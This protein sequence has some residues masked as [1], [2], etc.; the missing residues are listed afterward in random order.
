MRLTE[1]EGI[2]LSA[3]DL[4]G[5]LACHHLTAS[6][7]SAARGEIEPPPWS[8]PIL[9]AIRERGLE[10]EAKYLEQLR[11]QD[12]ELH[13]VSG[14]GDRENG[15]ARTEQAMRAGAP[16]IVQAT[17]AS[18]GWLG[19]ADV[20]LRVDEPSDLGAWSYEVVDTK[21]ARETS[22][23][24]I[25][26]LCL[27]SELVREIQGTLP[28]QMH[29]VSPGRDFAPNSYRVLDYLA[30]HRWVKQQLEI[31]VDSQ[32]QGS[33][34]E[35]YPD[36]CSHCEVCRWRPICVRRRRA[37]DHLCL[38]AGI[39]KLQI[40]ELHSRGIEHLETLARLPL[41]LEWKPERGSAEGY[42]RV[43]EQARVQLQARDE[44]RPVFELLPR[45]EERGLAR[46]PEP[47][48]RDV[49]FDIEGDSFAGDGGRE[50][51]FGYAFEGTQG[52]LEYKSTWALE[53]SKERAMFEQFVA[54]MMQRWATDP[55]FHIYH[56][57]AYEPSTLK[58]L[59]GRYATCED[60]IDRML[61]AGV[62]VDLYSV[63]RQSILA[64]V[65]SYSI[66]KLEPL[67]GYTREEN[68][69]EVRAHLSAVERALELGEADSLPD[70]VLKAVETY[71]RD[72][73]IATFKLRDWLESLRAEAVATGE[74][75][76]RPSFEPG[77]PSE[78]LSDRQLAIQELTADLLREVPEDP[79]IWTEVHKALWRLAHML[80]W[81]W[82]EEKVAWWE[83][84]RLV[85][86]DPEEFLDER[87]GVSGLRFKDTVGGTSRCPIH[88]YSYPLQEVSFKEGDTLHEGEVKIGSVFSIDQAARRLDV[89]KTQK[90]AGQH[91]SAVFAHDV[92]STGV[93]ASA[94][95]RF[96]Q[97]VAVH[98]LDADGSFRAARDLL[99][100]AA[101]RF[102]GGATGLTRGPNEET[103][104]FAERLALE[105][106]QGT[107]PVQGPPGSGKTF[108][109]ARMIC[110]LVAAGK[111][112]G[113]T[114]NSHK[115]IRNLLEEVV[116]AARERKQP[117]T[118]VEKVSDLSEC[119]PEGIL[120]VSKNADVL[121][122]LEGGEAQVAAG[123]AW[124]WARDEYFES[125][126]ILFVDEAGQ[127]S[128]AN[129]LA[130][131]QAGKS[132]VLLGDPQQLEQPQQG[133]HPEGTDVSALEHILGES[134]TIADDR[135]LFLPE[136]WRLHPSLS[137]FTS[138]VFYD[139]RLRSR[140]EL[141]LQGIEGR[142]PFGA[143]GLWFV[144]VSHAGNQ[145]SSPEEAEVVA[146]LIARLTAPGSK[147]TTAKGIENPLGLDEV[148]I[149]APYN[150]QVSL[151]SEHL[152]PDARVGTVDK[153]QGQEAPVVIYSM[154]TSTP[155]EA[156]R[157]MEFLYSPNRL[158]VATSRARCACI[159]VGNPL[160]FEPDC[161]TPRQMELANAF[162]R[163][164]E[165]SR[166][167]P[168]ARQKSS[169]HKSGLEF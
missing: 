161:R 114:A 47:T 132:L 113:I 46:L 35:T 76:Q 108:S 81:H 28:R 78:K 59:M 85:E 1:S 140:P 16:A 138:E 12:V 63:A 39:S 110:T 75:I 92:V 55:G 3:T 56:Y 106:D 20:L 25:L 155:E 61:R 60:E 65:E 116:K 91:P 168:W 32:L 90:A 98:G 42:V 128:L 13:D 4:A 67:F 58:R 135:G 141:E 21:L 87:A 53:T 9:A 80:G 139:G 10:H 15:V 151:L 86:M 157:G 34:E 163:Y 52:R 95:F 6:N 166:V 162:C 27:Y 103:L 123:T 8:N 44:K 143:P 7:I 73:C 125:V 96:G 50:Y 102:A 33:A 119:E 49:F 147:W 153:F 36:P 109:G 94:L 99:L 105:L 115:V 159:L 72:D 38:V 45:E 5:H 154:T 77:D 144:P 117:L 88:Q 48:S 133:S 146:E 134:D 150:A 130:V 111:K 57:A 142:E 131:A 118:C 167:V 70:K 149:V 43:R 18:D 82:R 74:K 148:L 107:L 40:K 68:L 54:E 164:L 121:A 37:D 23:G 66:K 41:P 124:L 89:K 127:M 14:V 83:Y 71:N 93:L 22:G 145:S 2:R 129:A 120:E 64:G 17:L 126:D 79:E 104:G 29:V 30:Y 101:P 19:I 136:T 69:E 122:A 169:S 137:E 11:G 62:F 160:L 31:F 158:N 156:P 165:I 100:S 51:L 112:V 152:G 97:W 26:Q 24:T 84:Y